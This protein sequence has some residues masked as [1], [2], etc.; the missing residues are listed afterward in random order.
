MKKPGED[1]CWWDVQRSVVDAKYSTFS[2]PFNVQ[3]EDF[4]QIISYT[5]DDFMYYVQTLSAYQSYMLAHP[6]A[7]HLCNGLLDR[8]LKSM[9][10]QGIDKNTYLDIEFPYFTITKMR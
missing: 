8:F 1:G 4:T 5:V 9:E 2:F 3:T 6:G 10:I 7:Q